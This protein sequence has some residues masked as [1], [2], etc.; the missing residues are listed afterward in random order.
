MTLH[1]EY[2][3]MLVNVGL[4]LL[5]LYFLTHH[6]MENQ[7]EAYPYL[8]FLLISATILSLL[9]LTTLKWLGYL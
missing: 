8:A 7:Y 2:T 3:I 4:C 9:F 6:E 5:V 1:S